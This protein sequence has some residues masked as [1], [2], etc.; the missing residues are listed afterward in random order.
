MKKSYIIGIV[1]IALAI[2]A[3]FAS[4]GDAS[5]YATFSEA[6]K[7]EGKEF[8]VVGKLDRSKEMIYNPQQDPNIF[9]FYM[10]DSDSTER[11]VTLHQGKPQDFDHTEQIV[12]IGK[13]VDKD[14]HASSLLMKCPSKYVDTKKQQI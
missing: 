9:I 2:G 11:K 4:L 1:L 6:Q 3:I 5:T 8:H 14:F 12:A 10:K 7:H 13:C